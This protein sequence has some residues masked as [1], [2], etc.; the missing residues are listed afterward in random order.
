MNRLTT[1]VLAACLGGAAHAGESVDLRLDADPL[2]KVRIDIVRGAV[3]VEG[4]GDNAVRVKGT[5]DDKSKEF[6][7]ERNGREILIED[8]LKHRSG[9]GSGEG[10]IITVYV[11]R[12]STVEMDTVSATQTVQNVD[13]NVR[14]ESV[15]GDISAREVRDDTA[16]SSVSGSIALAGATGEVRLESVSGDIEAD[17]NTTRLDVE[18]V[19]GD[20]VVRNA[21]I[22]QRLEATT[23]SGD[24][25]VRT[26]L[27]ADGEASLESVSGDIT[28]V[29]RGEVDA[30]FYAETGPGGD[31]ENGLSDQRP[32]RE[33][34]VG[35]ESLDMR[36]GQGSADV[37]ASVVT[38]TISLLKE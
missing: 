8:E 5:R 34:Y 13:G 36:V 11:P 21:G 15:S 32:Q 12:G 25:E 6:I 2:S 37:D 19:S 17:V 9:G 22:L 3:T 14:L 27:A 4:W 30:R 20:A 10:T 1:M 38:G 24:L 7:F 35:A 29:L 28:L 26:A 33:R 31:I 16:I 18:A 23:V